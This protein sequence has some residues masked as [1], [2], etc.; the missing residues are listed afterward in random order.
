MIPSL[1]N[2]TQLMIL[3]KCL[4]LLDEDSSGYMPVIQRQGKV[5]NPDGMKEDISF[6]AVEDT[7]RI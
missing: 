1:S 5:T 2:R 4:D 7:G 6:I 3:T